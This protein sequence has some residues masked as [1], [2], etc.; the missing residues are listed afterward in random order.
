MGGLLCQ[1]SS[2]HPGS[3]KGKDSRVLR[4]LR[5]FGLIDDDILII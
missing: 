5:I 4:I 1:R 3:G 2:L